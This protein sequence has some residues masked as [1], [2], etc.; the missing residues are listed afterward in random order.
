VPLANGAA[1]RGIEFVRHALVVLAFPPL[2]MVLVCGLVVLG[3][4]LRPRVVR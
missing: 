4:R 2:L 1:A 3:Q